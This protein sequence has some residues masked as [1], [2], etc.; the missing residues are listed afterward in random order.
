MLKYLFVPALVATSLSLAPPASAADETYL[1]AHSKQTRCAALDRWYTS[2]VEI[3]GPD[4]LSPDIAVN[5]MQRSTA[6]GFVDDVFVP[7]FGKPF[8]QLS[9]GERK[10]IEKDIGSCKQ[11]PADESLRPYLQAAFSADTRFSMVRGW[12]EAIPRAQAN[13][14]AAAPARAARAPAPTTAPA[15]P[16]GLNRDGLTP[17]IKAVEPNLPLGQFDSRNRSYLRVVHADQ[18]MYVGANFLTGCILSME[19]VVGVELPS[20]QEFTAAMAQKIF[21]DVLIPITRRHCGKVDFDLHAR[22]Y[23]RSVSVTDQ[24]AVVAVGSVKIASEPSYGYAYYPLRVALP[25]RF[26]P[27]TNA[28]RPAASR[29]AV[30]YT[31]YRP[32]RPRDSEAQLPF[33]MLFQQMLERDFLGVQM[34]AAI[35]AD[36]DPAA[37]P[38]RRGFAFAVMAFSRHCRAALGA[39]PATFT[40][41]WLEEVGTTTEQTTPWLKSVTK[42]MERK[43][44]ETFY[45]APDWK[46][47]FVA[48]H[49][50]E[51]LLLTRLMLSR[52]KDWTVDD[53]IGGAYESMIVDSMGPYHD[54][55]DG[56]IP[57]M[58]CD[59]SKKL[60][61]N[62]ND[63]LKG[64]KPRA[65]PNADYPKVVE[66][67]M[68]DGGVEVQTVSIGALP[69]TEAPVHD[70]TPGT[71]LRVNYYG[72]RTGVLEAYWVRN[73]GGHVMLSCFYPE[74]ETNYT[75]AGYTQP[76]ARQIASAGAGYR[77][78][79]ARCPLRAPR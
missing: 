62:W 21:D 54:T 19:Y 17:D 20:G 44:G 59:A 40:P 28:K 29:P 57:A 9:A 72:D 45:M 35:D 46:P 51:D 66:R 14:A 24:G 64:A 61:E 60:V 25:M 78:T 15:Q 42:H 33:A 2:I 75:L 27:G 53:I 77:G 74:G 71:W 79:A 11:A 1:S 5:L 58:G 73:A 36:S 13:P 7:A 3:A 50:A 38:T 6:R 8:A 49:G 32:A 10:A 67:R 68:V 48:I 43:F 16:R 39:N 55:A 12:Q 4:A 70:Y 65:R 30:E 47:N 23:P 18:R 69:A 41:T 22:F 31:N 26:E 52:M 76:D 63:F 56:F 37:Q 34:G